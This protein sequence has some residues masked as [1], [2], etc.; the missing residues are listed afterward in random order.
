MTKFKVGQKVYKVM[1][2]D[3]IFECVVTD[4]TVTENIDKDGKV[5][6]EKYCA[7]YEEKVW[8]LEC[9]EV[10]TSFTCS[11]HNVLSSKK[12]ALS[13]IDELKAARELLKDE[14]LNG[15]IDFKHLNIGME[16]PSYRLTVDAV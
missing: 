9:N 1:K 16:H 7:S 4:I 3:N 10:V 13:F 8:M 12:D 15:M 2:G 14:P 11:D 6:K 5:R